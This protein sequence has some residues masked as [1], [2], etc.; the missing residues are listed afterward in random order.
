MLLTEEG[1]AFLTEIL[2]THNPDLRDE[3]I[4]LTLELTEIDVESDDRTMEIGELLADQ[5]MSSKILGIVGRALYEMNEKLEEE[6][7]GVFK[8]LGV[9][10]NLFD[11]KA[12]AVDEVASSSNIIEWLVNRITT[13]VPHAH[14]NLLFATEILSIVL[15]SGANQQAFVTLQYVPLLTLHLRDVLL[16]HETPAP[17]SLDEQEVILNIFNSLALVLLQKDAQAVFADNEGIDIMLKLL[18]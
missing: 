8:L 5:L 18:K 16:L 1:V 17:P 13:P 15:S 10:E 3:A 2:Q 7:E 9:L 4:T 11:L 6:R 12:A 14:D